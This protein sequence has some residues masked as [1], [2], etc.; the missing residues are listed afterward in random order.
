[1]RRTREIVCVVALGSLI[2][3]DRG[4]VSGP[5]EVRMGRDECVEC[6]MMI[7]EDRCCSALVIE[8]EGE[9]RH[10]LF[11]DIGCMLDYEQEKGHQVTVFDR[12]V[13]DYGKRAWVK[14]ESAVIVFSPETI[15]TPMA[16]GIVAFGEAGDA[17]GLRRTAGGRLMTYVEV[18]SARR[19]WKA[20]RFGG[21]DG[22][23]S[24]PPK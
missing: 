19:E 10:A 7:N 15:S 8:F 18:A 1:M 4:V 3:C 22:A 6:G 11:D 16:T 20:A 24:E 9:R 13:R 17:E 5:P 23:G 21:R 14:A 2:G 12:F